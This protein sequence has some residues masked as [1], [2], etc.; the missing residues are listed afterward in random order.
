MMM[1]V[2]V[3]TCIIV[4]AI[5]LV[6]GPANA[7]SIFI[8]EVMASNGITIADEDGDY[9]DWIELNN[10][11]DKEVNLEGY[12][13]SDKYGN[14][15]VWLFPDTVLG[16]GEFLVIW[17]SGKNRTTPGEALHTNFSI[18]ADGEELILT[19]PTNERID[20]LTPIAIPRDISYGRQPDGGSE[21]YFFSEPTPGAPNDTPAFIGQV[22]SPVF[23]HTGGFYH[24]PLDLSIGNADTN[25]SIYY[26]LDGSEPT[27]SSSLYG[28][29]IHIYDRDDIP[30]DISEI[31]T[32]TNYTWRS[33]RGQVNKVMVVRARA[34]S[35]GYLPSE[36]VTHTYIVDS[37]VSERYTFPLLSI[38]THRDNF[39]DDDIGIYVPGNHYVPPSHPR[40]PFGSNWVI[41]RSG[42]RSGNGPYI[43]NISAEMGSAS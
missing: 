16:P 25:I 41:S 36:T 43:W 15:F 23:A 12:G 13:L 40:R 18:S 29:S 4:L 19:S 31:P 26:T 5:V 24:D 30:N 37:A 3:R 11:G 8:N 39:F 10:S 22:D 27:D 28:E 20:E 33:P 21:W 1:N 2:S 34:F 42:D 14:A 35:D 6:Y 17:A 32:N 7:Q 38:A 9:E